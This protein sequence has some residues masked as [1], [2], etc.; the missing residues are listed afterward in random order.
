MF[1]IPETAAHDTERT[2]SDVIAS[3]VD[4]ALVLD[5]IVQLPAPNMK[6]LWRRDRDSNPGYGLPYTHFPGVRL[7]PLGHL[8]AGNAGYTDGPV[9]CKR[10]VT[11]NAPK[12]GGSGG[13]SFR[14]SP[15]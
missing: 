8:S 5:V 12:R 7:R 6:G 4:E 10:V 9:D 3:V 13:L 11:P 15:R 2:G 1:R 14:S